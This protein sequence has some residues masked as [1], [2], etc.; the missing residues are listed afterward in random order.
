MKARKSTSAFGLTALVLSAT[1]QGSWAASKPAPFNAG[2]VK[3]ALVQNSGA[4]DYFQQWTNGAKKQA[5]A[6]GFD[7]QI[8]D[9][10]ADNAKQTT[11]META[12]GSGV[13]GI[14]VDHGN[15]DTMCPGINKAIGCWNSSCRL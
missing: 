15:A 1:M 10:Q 5:V 7:M 13:K 3:I 6:V 9:A 2:P 11:D 4:G 12:V 8:Y 14:I